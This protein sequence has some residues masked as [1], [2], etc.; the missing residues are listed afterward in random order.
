MNKVQAVVE[1]LIAAGWRDTCD[2]Q[3]VGIEAALPELRAILAAA[4]T[5]PMQ[6]YPNH[7]WCVGCTPDECSGCG[8]APAAP[9]QQSTIPTNVADA[10]AKY[11]AANVAALKELGEQF[12]QGA[13]IRISDVQAKSIEA[14]NELVAVMDA[15]IAAEKGSA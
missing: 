9:E 4:P 8:T 3:W 15:A 6:P 10:Y 7:N 1:I 2:A 14:F 12:P 13:T 11:K 5:A